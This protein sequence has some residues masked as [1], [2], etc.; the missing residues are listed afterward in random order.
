MVI[1]T[2]LGETMDIFEVFSGRHSIR[3]F[4]DREVPDEVLGKIFEAVNRAPSAGNLQAFDIYLVTK[5]EHKEAL[6]RASHD[7]EFLVQSPLVLVFCAVPTRSSVRYAERGE[8]LYCIQDATIACTFAMLA[9]AALGLDSVWV[10]AFDENAVHKIIK[11]EPGHRP[12]TMLPL[13][14]RDE[15]PRIRPRRAL[16]E[17][18]HRVE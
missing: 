11:A 14:Y 12:V 17:I 8:T 2:T 1:K 10:G 5:K 9:A 6:C 4:T 15:A 13:G 18:V 3:A 7:Q 16:D